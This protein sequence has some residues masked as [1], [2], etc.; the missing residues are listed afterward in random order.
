MQH[1]VFAITPDRRAGGAALA[2]VVPPGGERRQA[3]ESILRIFDVA[4]NFRADVPE[5][6]ILLDLYVHE[7]DHRAVTVGD[8]CVA[9]SISSS[10]AQRTVGRLLDD[11]L[12]IRHK[13]PLD[14][15]RRLL[16]LTEESRSLLTGFIDKCALEPAGG[17]RTGQRHDSEPV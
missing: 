2:A 15:R 7:Q 10:S 4:Q 17:S 5:L 6:A 8:A 1:P 11:G 3:A 13:D 9:A 12:V 14:A 16:S